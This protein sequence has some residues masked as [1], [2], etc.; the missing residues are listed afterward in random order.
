MPAGQNI[1][2]L[3]TPSNY[4]TVAE[5][6][7]NKGIILHLPPQYL[8]EG[9]CLEAKNFLGVGGGLKRRP[10]ISLFS[11][12]VVPHPPWQDLLSFWS[13][14]GSQTLIGVDQRF[15]YRVATASNTGLY[16][17]FHPAAAADH[18]TVS[19]TP[20]ATNLVTNDTDVHWDDA[21]NEIQHGDMLVYGA[22]YEY[23]EGIASVTNGTALVL[24]NVAAY[25]HGANWKIRRAFG[26]VNPSLV[27]STVLTGGAPKILFADGSRF[28]YSYDG[29]TFTDYNAAETG[30]I[31]S[32]VTYFKN[33]IWI[34]NI[35]EATVQ[36]RQRIR[37]TELG[38]MD[39]F[40]SGGYLDLPYVKGAIKRLVP[41]GD[42]LVA[43]FDDAI[44]VGRPTNLLNM[45]LSFQKLETGGIGL[46]GMK[47][48][49]E[50]IDSLFFVGQDDIYALSPAG[51]VAVG[52]PV[53]CKTI[54]ETT[55]THHWKICS[56]T[57]LLNDRVVFGFPKSSDEVEEVWSYN[58]KTK[59]WT[60]DGVNC[61]MLAS[62]SW[63]DNLTWEDFVT[64]DYDT[65]HVTMVITD[66]TLV[67]TAVDWVT[68]G[69]A[70]GD[71]ILID[72]LGTG[73]YDFVTTVDSVTNLTTIE[74]I[75]AA[76][77]NA[78][79]VHYRIVKVASTWEGSQLAA[80]LSWESIRGSSTTVKDIYILKYDTIWKY[81]VE[82]QND[83]GSAIGV[84]L[85]T[86]DM[87]FN[88]PDDDKTF[89]ELAVKVETW[90]A[91]NVDFTVSGSSDRGQHWK[92]LGT[93]RIATNHDE[94]KVNFRLKGACCRFRLTSISDVASYTLNELTLKVR[95]LGAEVQG[96][97]DT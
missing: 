76:D 1:Q 21:V 48:V 53:V 87:D 59:A 38:D 54:A 25:Y 91:S 52:T 42:F 75:D 66:K 10:G 18:I 32:C 89:Y 14:T 19:A 7:Y 15:A 37:W 77:V 60:W 33:R 84:E 81:V 72:S 95:G 47:A 3:F 78:A 65:G 64:Q 34:A 50:W 2:N 43:F 9:A 29:T 4:Q 62:N 12:I 73:N 22:T 6:P 93:L 23:E 61:H 70:P 41:L 27:D 83:N 96:R 94:G 8:P 80:Y 5:R 28:L 46:L 86:R 63:V 20:V 13:A 82:G 35:L 39:D 49:T 85:V 17:E 24:T 55:S 57:D 79:L 88:V 26:A 69:V 71:S 40:T 92:A 97:E 44:Y 30:F 90:V 45:P 58:Y 36:H 74:M 16:W 56:A 67:G 11:S 68:E 51:L 31:P